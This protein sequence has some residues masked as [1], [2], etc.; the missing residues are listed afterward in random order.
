MWKLIGEA[1]GFVRE[2]I[3]RRFKTRYERTWK[4]NDDEIKDALAKGSVYR[5]NALFKRLRQ[6]GRSSEESDMELLE[7]GNYSVSP[8]WMEERLQF[9]N[10]MVKRLQEWH[11]TN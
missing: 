1:I 7:N 6:Q 11:S 5:L 10:N 8:A 4:E 9:E 2:T 3:S